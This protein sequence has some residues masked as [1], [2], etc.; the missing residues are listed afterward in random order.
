MTKKLN[1]K[2]TC[3]KCGSE[4]VYFK[5]DG[6]FEGIIKANSEDRDVEIE[7]IFI[8]KKMSSFCNNCGAEDV[9]DKIEYIPRNNIDTFKN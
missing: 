8:N 4:D 5:V 3:N 1:K 9:T 6:R 2:I 7:R